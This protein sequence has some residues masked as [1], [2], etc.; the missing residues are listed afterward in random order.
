M[1]IAVIAL[2]FDW[3][4]VGTVVYER[5]ESQFPTTPYGWDAFAREAIKGLNPD[6]K[7]FH[8]GIAKVEGDGEF[9]VSQDMIDALKAEHET[10][11]LNYTETW[12]YGNTG[13]VTT[14]R[15]G[16]E[17]EVRLKE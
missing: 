1:K 15:E 11:R 16:T 9:K 6:V 12:E 13:S 17:T 10:K 5:D 4:L 3:K 8:V 2:D 14:L 7:D